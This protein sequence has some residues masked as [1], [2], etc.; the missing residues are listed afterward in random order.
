MTARLGIAVLVL[1]SMSSAAP[2]QLP[3]YDTFRLRDGEIVR[4]HDP[5]FARCLNNAMGSDAEASRC[6]DIEAENQ[7]RALNRAYRAAM[8]RQRNASA[9]SRLRADQRR[10]LTVRHRHCDREVEAQTGAA[11]GEYGTLDRLSWHFCALHDVTRRTVWLER[12]S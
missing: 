7:D 4:R 10:W 3:R 8:A 9:R 2:A 6:I 11:P 12:L 1:V 5:Y